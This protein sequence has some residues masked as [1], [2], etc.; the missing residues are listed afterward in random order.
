MHIAMY[1]YSI[2][3]VTRLLLFIVLLFAA[4]QLCNAQT[5]A[6]VKIKSFKKL[7]GQWSGALT[8]L[9]YTSGKPYT[10]PADISITQIGNTA[11]FAF[12]NTYPN[13]PQA[14]SID[15]LQITNDGTLINGERVVSVN[16]LGKG[17]TSVI[18]EMEGT[19]G[20]DDANAT[21]RNTYYISKREYKVIKEVQ[22]AGQTIWIKRHEYSHSRVKKKRK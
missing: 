9:D 18:T 13:E 22:F 15:T 19:D 3:L 11:L 6:K 17:K 7:Q 20:N 14:N 16:Q 1:K 2:M 10:M 4:P 8:Y 21:I 5:T 12:S